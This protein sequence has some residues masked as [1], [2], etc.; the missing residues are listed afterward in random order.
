M[1]TAIIITGGMRS[2]EKCLPNLRWSVFRHFP[3]AKFYCVTSDDDDAHKTLQVPSPALCRKVKQ[4]ELYAPLGCR[5]EWHGPNT[6]YMHEP[7]NISVPPQAVL[8]QLW[9]LREG[10]RLYQEAND[11]AEIV[12]RCRPDLWFQE[13]EL[14]RP[15][16]AQDSSRNPFRDVNDVAFTPFWGRFGGCNDRFAILGASAAQEYFTT[17]DKIPMLIKAGC[18]L[19]PESLIKASL[20]HGLIHIEDYLWAIFGTLRTSGEMRHPEIIAADLAHF[21]KS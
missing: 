16:K 9:M 11:P 17:Y 3:D 20:T 13:F 19:H 7:Y 5:K 10:W 15:L 4:P 2:F 8:G 18:A 12:I 21:S 14:P 1:K 6:P